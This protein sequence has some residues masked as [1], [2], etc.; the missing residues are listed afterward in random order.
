M[1]LRVSPIFQWDH[2]PLLTVTSWSAGLAKFVSSSVLRLLFTSCTVYA[3]LVALCWSSPLLVSIGSAHYANRSVWR[4]WTCY[5]EGRCI[6]LMS[7]GIVDFGSDH[8]CY[9]R[10]FLIVL[11]FILANVIQIPH[12]EIHFHSVAT[13]LWW[14]PVCI[15]THITTYNMK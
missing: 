5:C 2:L 10:S 4:R 7:P 13:N 14:I 1:V 15:R 6:I 9:I 11:L 3:W 12:I 8:R